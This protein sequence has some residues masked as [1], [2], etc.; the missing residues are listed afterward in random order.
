MGGAHRF[1]ASPPVL[2]Q[3][4]LLPNGMIYIVTSHLL[5][6]TVTLAL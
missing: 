2:L 6:A 5:S 3:V 4:H 1:P